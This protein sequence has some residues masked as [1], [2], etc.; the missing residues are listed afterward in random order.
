MSEKINRAVFLEGRK[1][2]KRLQARFRSYFPPTV[3]TLSL[4]LSGRATVSGKR[5][6]T[7]RTARRFPMRCGARPAVA[8]STVT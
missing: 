7:P 1:L 6:P 8:G 4:G 5:W 2:L 3:E